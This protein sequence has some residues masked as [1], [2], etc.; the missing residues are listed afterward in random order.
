MK[1]RILSLLLT[2]AMML[3]VMTILPISVSAETN[4]F[5]ANDESPLISTAAD[6]VAFAAAVDGGNNFSGKTVKLAADID[7]SGVE[8]FSDIGAASSK[9][10]SGSFDG[11]GHAITNF[12]QSMGKFDGQGGLFAMVRVPANGTVEIKNFTIDGTMTYN[13]TGDSYCVGTVVSCL[14][15]GT[16]K[17]AKGTFT[18]Q[19]VR[20]SVTI[21]VNGSSG[22]VY[23]VGGLLG[24]TRHATD[25]TDLT[26]NIDSC[27]YDG[28][29]NFG[30]IT[31]FVGGIMGTA[32]RNVSNRDVTINITNTVFAGNINL[33]WYST[34]VA[35]FA[36]LT[37]DQDVENKGGLIVANITDCISA[38]KIFFQ[39]EQ[40]YDSYEYGIAC[41]TVYGD[42]L[43]MNVKNLY[44]VPFGIPS[45]NASGERIVEIVQEGKNANNYTCDANSGAKTLDEISSLTAADFSE[46]AKF[47]FK[48]NTDIDTYYP[49]PT[50]LV[51]EGAWVD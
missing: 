20:S 5:N 31:R 11:Q 6:L 1:K 4:T 45:D 10:F 43:K 18:M 19:N 2:V 51:K 16:D 24:F 15:A 47:S 14:D 42:V 32:G 26:V 8:N 37:R 33:P 9:P 35:T 46:N 36:C 44:Y 30:R 3:S 13:I 12:K 40:T 49:C 23:G 28:N 29:M 17:T 21:Q 27:V 39:E 7:L 22:T 34:D 48:A 41:S 25:V 50:G 38:G